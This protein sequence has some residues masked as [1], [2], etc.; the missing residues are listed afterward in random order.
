[1]KAVTA[2]ELLDLVRGFCLGSLSLALL[3]DRESLGTEFAGARY[4]RRARLDSDYHKRGAHDPQYTLH[5]P[6]RAGKPVPALAPT[7][8]T[9]ARHRGLCMARHQRK[10]GPI[11]P[12]RSWLV[13]LRRRRHCHCSVVVVALLWLL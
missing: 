9:W 2:T 13:V 4:N 12:G 11:S 7:I 3:V 5:S 6:V 10:A 1:M 8:G